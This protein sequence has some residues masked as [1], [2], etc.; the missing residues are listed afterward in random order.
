[1]A[2]TATDLPPPSP[3]RGRRWALA[4]LALLAAIAALPLALDTGPGRAWLV[5]QLPR[6]VLENGLS[7]R[8]ARI[9][10]SLWGKATL[11]DVQLHDPQGG[12]AHIDRLAL[13][14]QPLALAYNQFVAANIDVARARVTRRPRLL[15]TRDPRLLPKQDIIVDRLRIARLELAPGIAGPERVISARGQIDIRAGRA[16]VKLDA[17]A[18]GATGGDLLA[19]D[20]DAEPDRNR[21][22]LA[23]RLVAPAGGVVTSLAG[24]PRALTATANGRGTWQAWTGGLRASF[25]DVAAPL[26]D[27]ALAGRDGRLRA[28]GRI[29]PAQLLATGP[30]TRLLEG[31]LAVT[32]DARP[33]GDTAQLLLTANGAALSGSASGRID[34]A[35]ERLSDAQAQLALA[36][37]APLARQYGI[38][39]LKG[40]ARLAGPML[41]PTADVQLAARSLTLPGQIQ[42]A[43]VGLAGT[44]DLNQRPIAAPLQLTVTALNG[45]PAAA[46]PLA[47]AWRGD[48]RLRWQGGEVKGETIRLR[49]QAATLTLGFGWRPATGGWAVDGSADARAWPLPGLGSSEALLTFK[50][51][52][53]AGGSTTGTG[54]LRLN[55]RQPVAAIARLTDGA[56]ALSIQFTLSSGLALSF[57]DLELASP[58]LSAT[59]SAS[60]RDGQF[61]LAASGRSRDWGGFGMNGRG[62]LAVPHFDARFA[63]PGYGLSAVALA[64]DPAGEGWRLTGDAQ[65]SLGAVQLA[66]GIALTPVLTLNVERLAADTLVASGRITQTAAGPFTGQ[67]KLAG[68]GLEGKALLAA[69]G[70]VQQA[71]IDLGGTGINLP[72]AVPITIDRLA[73]DARLLLPA[74]G[75]QV[76]GTLTLTG[77]ERG[78]LLLERAD[79]RLTLNDGKGSASLTVAGNSGEEFTVSLKAAIAP[80]RYELSGEGDYDGRKARLA[81]PA[82]ITR[83]ADGWHLARTTLA[84]GLGNAELAADW[85][86][87]RHVEARLDKVSLG[88][89]QLLYPSIDLA[90]RVSGELRLDWPKGA[91]PVGT[92]A[93]RVNGLSRSNVAS[94]STPIDVGLNAALATGGSSLK[95]VI[96]RAGKAEGRLQ[97]RLGPVAPG[98]AGLLDRLAAASIVGQLRY[99]GPAQDFWGL[100]GLTA[101]DVRGPVQLA[102]D[103]SG[104]LG[105]P[106]VSGRLKASGGRVEAPL[107]GAVATNVGL[108]AR[109]SA[110]RLELQRFSGSS[111]Q[112]S[113]TG[114][115][116]IDLSWE[117]GFPMDIRMAVKDAAILGRDDLTATGSGNVRVATDEYGGVVSGTLNLS[118][119]EY[120]VGRTAVADVPVLAVTEKNTRL[121]GRRA[122]QY[123]PPTRWL[124]NLNLK[125]DNRLKVT[126]MGIN[127]EWQADVRLRGGTTAPELFGRVQLVRGDYDFAGKRFQLTRGDIRF[128]GG[129][130]PDPIITVSAENTGNGFTALLNIEGTAQRPQIKFSSV[131]ALPEDEVLSRVLFGSS[132]TDLSAIE[133]VQLAGALASLRGGSGFNP[134]GA[135]GKGLGI[136]RLRILPADQATGRRTTYA[137]GQY[138]GRNVYV[139]LATDAQGYTATSIEIGLTRSLSVLSSVA[140]LGGTS[141][142]V[143]WK[144][145]Y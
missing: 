142:S 50:L 111:G 87:A 8:V 60:W 78:S 30:L 48:G 112:G 56:A 127:S 32:A 9:D 43:G 27:L 16:L 103:L 15:P 120:R 145:D 92:V 14:W 85:G 119:A 59:G 83:D 129:Y 69:N 54:S 134:V 66:A 46:A 113:I 63:N 137:A 100:S 77:L 31:G 91:T 99:A 116:T 11:L 33:D 6:L 84:S 24:L 81:V 140:T 86:D 102:A 106:T 45:L 117:R 90:G 51:R 123:V 58:G 39:G 61:T 130:P 97:A 101:L 141:A 35:S 10:G 37:S 110:S 76:T 17:R 28:D 126:G 22:A 104:T 26:A 29:D 52:P 12:F 68:R 57:T 128:V 131:P 89:V 47:G 70:T 5:Q 25:A 105:D 40:T 18:L 125:A 53:G 144:R 34:R 13:D 7:F 124:Y 108:D 80:N 96:V 65:S 122:V 49:G 121:I 36:D 23:T 109:F 41:A 62:T 44:I 3:R 74:S 118:R 71:D 38:I 79:G 64:L 42:L 93:L 82:L 115:G 143:R 75:P 107:L 133:A 2:E 1:M 114:S 73:L 135:I 19:L 139:E 136:D 4:A 94:T 132:V 67:L 21:F 98:D 55:A 138:L 20:L 88:V 95:A 72:L